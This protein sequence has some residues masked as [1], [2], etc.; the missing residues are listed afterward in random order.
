MLLKK[1]GLF[2]KLFILHIVSTTILFLIII[3]AYSYIEKNNF[4][5]TLGE[6]SVLIHDLLEISCVDPIVGTI[7][8]DR[9][10]QAIEAVYGKNQEIVYI[11]IYDPAALIIASIGELPEIHFGVET[12]NLLF[13]QGSNLGQQ[14]NIN[15]DRNELITY[16]K[17][18][19]RYLGLIRIE[20]TKKYL[21]QQLR[22]NILYFLGLFI[23]AIAVTSLI[24]YLFTNKWIVQPI[25]NVSKIM[26]SY[27]QAELPNLFST[28]KNYNKSI[29]KDEIGIMS[30][31]FERMISSIIKRTKEKEKAEE[32]YRLIAENIGDV[33]W[34]MDMDFNF[35]YISPS[36][37]QRRGYTAKEMMDQSTKDLFLPDSLEKVMELFYQTLALIESGDEAGFQQ[38]EFE[39]EQ[40]CKD[41]TTI[42]TSNTARILPG[43]EKQ[44]ERIVGIT[45][46]ITERM[47]AEEALRASHERF[48]TVLNSIDATI[49]VA[50]METYEILFMN[51]YMIESFNNDM[52]GEICWEVFRGESGPCQGCTNDQLIDENGNPTGVCTWQGKNPITGKWYSNYDRAIEWTDGR[53]VKL[54]IA[55]DISDLKNM[56][57]ELLQAHKME[58]IGTLAGGVAHDFNNIL[59]MIIGNAELALEDIPEWHP[60]YTYLDRIKS[61]SLKAAGI[62]KQL[63][64]FSRKI[65]QELKPLDVVSTIEDSLDFLRATIPTTIEILRQLPDLKITILADPIQINQILMN[66]CVNASQAMEDT[67]GI[68]KIEVET[69]AI[70]EGYT[71][72][73]PDL[74]PGKYV[75]IM[76]SDTGLGIKPEIIDRIFDPYFTTKE[77]GKG[78]GMGLAVVHGI[79][80]SH[81]GAISVDSKL[82]KGT[83]FTVLFPIVF[84][85]FDQ[86]P[87]NKIG[88]DYES[89]HVKE[90]SSPEMGG[91]EKILFVDDEEAIIDI[92]V[93]ML[94]RVG[95]R[96]AATTDPRE[97]FTLFQSKPHEFD[98]VITD[99]TMPQMTGAKLSGKIKKV[100][101][102][103]PVIICTG[104]SSLIDEETAEQLGI[105]AYVMKPVS[106]SEMAKTIRRV[107]DK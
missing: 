14:I 54:Q 104:H 45:R 65:E 81:S 37:Y 6:K 43:P 47:Q 27:G 57:E 13:N 102:D 58:S 49:Y 22:A 36:I 82:G 20:Y 90:M 69:E 89:D 16:L 98:L 41:G 35:T 1:T 30:A 39:A 83:T 10:F 25:V 70:E 52:T 29:A 56:E 86:E 106:M 15:Q 42:W 64:S 38:V 5:E 8:Y 2:D 75:K 103:I 96:V 67:G 3:V 66:L 60:L 32:M 97:A 105:A 51:K 26:D 101:S 31:A 34:T 73:F 72:D 92:A 93:Q 88:A 62:V 76:V 11:E 53:L 78:S 61:A 28:I 63:L 18:G 9:A 87:E 79:V 55:T 59:Y 94:E 77:I 100:R 99:M 7:A 40:P 44:P 74:A 23:I 71:K 46:D 17:A 85:I 107:M 48:L 80:K 33:V 84:P 24:F 91:T 95:Y 68:L 21:I 12:I 4:N 50:D 19:D